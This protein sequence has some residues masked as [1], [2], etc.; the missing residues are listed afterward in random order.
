MVRV[1]RLDLSPDHQPQF[2]EGTVKFLFKLDSSAS[3]LNRGGPIQGLHSCLL[4][5]EGPCPL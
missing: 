5:F 3:G 4:W 2:S 1:R